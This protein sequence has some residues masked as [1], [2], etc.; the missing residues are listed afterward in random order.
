ML[1][2]R[3][4][5]LLSQTDW[6]S[7]VV[8]I[9]TTV[10][11][12]N[13]N[14]YWLI[15]IVLL[16]TFWPIW[17]LTKKLSS[18]DNYPEVYVFL[19]VSCCFAAYVVNVLLGP[20]KTF[21]PA[22]IETFALGAVLEV[23]PSIDGTTLMDSG[24]GFWLDKQGH[25]MTASIPR[26][27]DVTLGKP[28]YIGSV[29]PIIVQNEMTVGGGVTYRD[30]YAIYYDFETGIK[31]IRVDN[32]PFTGIRSEFLGVMEEANVPSLAHGTSETG[33]KIFVTVLVW[34]NQRM[35]MMTLREG[36]ITGLSID[37]SVKG[38][39]RRIHTDI[40]FRKS[41]SG[42][43]VFNEYKEVIGIVSATSM[44]TAELISSNYV[45][46]ICMQIKACGE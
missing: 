40:P 43:P 23:S 20:Q 42:S 28:L 9:I 17:K 22:V 3:D 5:T 13:G 38:N 11:P 2:Y 12:M 16:L 18:P 41:Y 14:I 32:N 39:Y 26:D 30:G 44:E 10:V 37:I 36:R 6:T 19:L 24:T 46:G 45:L 8:T 4:P 35:P 1:Q 29:I 15:G 33:S 27:K 7:I 21:S 31:I 25:L 34:D